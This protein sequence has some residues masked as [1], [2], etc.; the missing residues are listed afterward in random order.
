MIMPVQRKMTFALKKQRL[1]GELRPDYGNRGQQ[2]CRQN[3]DCRCH[4]D[5]S[6]RDA[7]IRWTGIG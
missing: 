4:P 1:L 2:I 5:I 6:G 7:V 3:D